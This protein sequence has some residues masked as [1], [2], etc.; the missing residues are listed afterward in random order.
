MGNDEG[1]LAVDTLNDM[2]LLAIHNIKMSR[3]RQQD[4]FS[5]YPVTE[6]LLETRYWSEITQEICVI[7]I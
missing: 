5:T 6:F 2:Y 3:E 7:Q 1:L 4:Y